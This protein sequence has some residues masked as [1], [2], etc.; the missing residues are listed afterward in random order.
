MKGGGP[1]PE[2]GR[3]AYS[4]EDPAARQILG[5]VWAAVFV[6]LL[7]MGIIVPILPLYA[8]SLGATSTMLGM[9]VAGF[10]LSRGLLQPLVGSYS[11]RHG[12]KRFVAT[13]LLIYSLSGLLYVLADSVLALFVVRMLH[14]A[15]SAM[16]VPVAM[17]YVGDLSPEGEEGRYMGTLNIAM[18]AGI[19][20]GPVVGGTFLDALG[21]ASPF[22]AMSALGAVS[23]ALVLVL[24]P[25]RRAIPSVEQTGLLDTLGRMAGDARVVGILLSRGMTMLAMVTSI[26]FLPL[27]MARFMNASGAEIGVVIAVRTL[28]NALFQAPFG[29]LADRHSR[30]TFLMVGTGVMAVVMLVIPLMTDFG[31][32]LIAFAVMGLGEAAVWPTLA[33]LATK[34]G[35]RYGQGAMMGVFNMAMSTGIFAGALGTGAIADVLGLQMAFVVAGLLLAASAVATQGLLS[36][37]RLVEGRGDRGRSGRRTATTQ[38]LPTTRPDRAQPQPTRDPVLYFIDPL[39]RTN[40]DLMQAYDVRIPPLTTDDATDEQVAAMGAWTQMNWVA[41]LAH[42]PTLFAAQQALVRKVI[43][44]SD[45]PPRERE[46]IVLRALEVCD[47]TYE[48]TH[49]ILLAKNVGMTDEEIEAARKGDDRLSDFE[50]LLARAAEE[51]VRDQRISDEVWAGLSEQYNTVQLLEVVGLV[52]AY[53]LIAMTTKTFGIQVEDD[54]V[55]HGFM[56]Q[57]NY[58]A[59]EQGVGTGL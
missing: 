9:M 31:P 36:T 52:A 28:T 5:T 43:P 47:E 56:H 34:E 7:G 1:Q 39:S 16:V 15:G 6:A 32:L 2:I 23:F 53:V 41:V 24:L 25:E 51:L 14:G 46:I 18:F 22:Y 26:T 58:V 19:G 33:A 44:Q 38:E 10:S 17:S 45:L 55:F 11:D 13:G 35:R 49:H 57:R 4:S 20:M 54:D 3:A 8:E 59:A 29:R 37:D 12:R 21:E 50:R 40:G 27:L 30:E 48:L 42:H